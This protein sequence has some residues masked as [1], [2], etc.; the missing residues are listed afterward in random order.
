MNIL[1]FDIGGTK[2]CVL[3]AKT[4]GEEI[5]F[6]KSKPKEKKTVQH[7]QDTVEP[8]NSNKPYED[9]A[10]DHQEELSYVDD[11]SIEMPF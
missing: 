8:V 2:S 10:K 5:E 1:G 3:L 9:F 6:L 7:T 11:A 4:D